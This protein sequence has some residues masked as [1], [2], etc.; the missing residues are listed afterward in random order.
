[1]QKKKIFNW[2]SSRQKGE[3]FEKNWYN[4]RQ[5]GKGFV[6]IG[7]VHVKE[8]KR[9][10][11]NCTVHEKN[12]ILKKNCRVHEKQENIFFKW[13]SPCK[14]EDLKKIAIVRVKS[15]MFKKTSTAH[16]KNQKSK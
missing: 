5:K 4:P 1:M 16:P 12:R 10:E 14:K 15:K 8:E 7:T 9:F 13:H 3:G 11:K 6:K 2:Y